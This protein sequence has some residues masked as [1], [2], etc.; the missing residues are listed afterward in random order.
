MKKRKILSLILTICM[1]L[2]LTPMVAYATEVVIGG[3]APVKVTTLDNSVDASSIS[4]DLYVIFR[5]AETG[6]EKPLDCIDTITPE[7]V[8]VGTF[9][10]V[11]TKAI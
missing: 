2:S 11:K 10:T 8:T 9:K 4:V 6:E 3:G 5:N 7:N 1:V